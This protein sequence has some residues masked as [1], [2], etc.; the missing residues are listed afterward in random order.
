[1]AVVDIVIG[2]LKVEQQQTDQIVIAPH[3]LLGG[4]AQP[5]GDRS[6][7][8]RFADSDRVTAPMIFRLPELIE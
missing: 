1:M 8:L 7:P 3:E 6:Q 4:L 2:D 5:R